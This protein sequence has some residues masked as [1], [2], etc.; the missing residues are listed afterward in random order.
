MMDKWTALAVSVFF[1]ATFG[2][3]AASQYEKTKSAGEVQVEC[4]KT[5]Q[6]AIAAKIDTIKFDCGK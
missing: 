1:I 6:A 4:Y 3:I 5:V 2:G